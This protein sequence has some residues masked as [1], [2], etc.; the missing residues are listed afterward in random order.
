MEMLNRNLWS[1]ISKGSESVFRA[2]WGTKHNLILGIE[3]LMAMPSNP[4]IVCIVSPGNQNKVGHSS[5]QLDTTHSV[6]SW[7]SDFISATCQLFSMPLTC[8]T[9]LSLL[10][11]FVSCPILV[12]QFPGVRPLTGASV[13]SVSLN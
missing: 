6:I 9:P 13:E 12:A 2:S 5:V 7:L 4:H 11:P 10:S 3:Q 1:R 8:G